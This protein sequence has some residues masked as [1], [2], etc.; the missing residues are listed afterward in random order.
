LE[1]ESWRIQTA[2]LTAAAFVGILA[3]S[4]HWIRIFTESQWINHASPKFLTEGFYNYQ[5]HFLNIR[6]TMFPGDLIFLCFLIFI[7]PSIS[8]LFFKTNAKIRRKLY[9]VISVTLV[10]LFMAT[11]Y[12]QFIWENLFVLQKIQFPWRWL[13]ITAIGAAILIA[14]GTQCLKECLG[15]RKFVL[16]LWIFVCVAANG[17]FTGTY[18]IGANL[19]DTGYFLVSKE[20]FNHE[21]SEKTTAKH[22]I[23]WQTIWVRESAF[24]LKNKVETDNR[25]IE[26]IKWRGFDKEFIVSEGN[27]SE[28]RV[29]QFYYP[30]WKAKVNN[31]DVPVSKT[32]DG[33]ILLSIPAETS[34]VRLTF[35]EPF[36]V[37]LFITVSIFSWLLIIALFLINWHKATNNSI[38][39]NILRKICL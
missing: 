24:N 30:Y 31:I 1:R 8:I 19:M 7:L 22:H 15:E 33:A 14:A 37:K 6:A 27:M 25:E 5:N 23:F 34:T 16:S 32:E 13:T 9:P 17:Y 3:A 18:I 28:V 39:H 21:V 36:I 38:V 29:A 2:K 26:V 4:F 11:S 20:K 35:V 10:S 12:S